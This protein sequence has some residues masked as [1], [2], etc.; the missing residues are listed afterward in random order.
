MQASKGVVFVMEGIHGILK[1]GGQRLYCMIVGHRW[2]TC[3]E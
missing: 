2:K 1:M 3:L